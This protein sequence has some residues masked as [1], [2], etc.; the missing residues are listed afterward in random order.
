MKTLVVVD[1][2]S[3]W[4][5]Q[6]P[7]AE[8]VTAKE[9]INNPKYA[10]VPRCHILNLCRS[11]N[12]QTLGYYVSLLASAR[13][14]KPTPTLTSIEDLK[15]PSMIRFISNELDDLI[16][17]LLS[18]IHSD[19]FT[20]SIYFG[21]NVAKT[22]DRLASELYRQ[23]LAPYMQARFLKTKERWILTSIKTIAISEIPDEHRGFAIKETHRHLSRKS[24]LKQSEKRALFDLAILVDPNEEAPPS[25]KRALQKFCKAGEQLGCSV[26]LITKADFGRVAEFDALF[27]RETTRVNHHTYRFARRAIANGLEVIDDPLS[28]LRCCNKVY[29]HELL[30]KH[31]IPTPY[32]V[33]V[34]KEH[35]EQVALSMDYPCVLKQPDSAFSQGVIRVRSAREFLMQAEKLLSGS[36]LFL[37]QEY[38][39]TE[40]DWRIGVLDGK[41]LYCCR[42][43]M[44]KNHWQIIRN[45][46]TGKM[47]E[48]G[49]TSLS[50]E[51]APERVL[52]LA[53]KSANLIGNGLYGVDI[54]EVN[55][56]FYVIEV[57]DNPTIDAGVEDETLK[58][59][60]YLKI[61][62]KICERIESKQDKIRQDTQKKYDKTLCKNQSV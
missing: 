31:K 62:G 39:P 26:E 47:Q 19:Q 35:V 18:K 48:G 46:H 22:Y 44:V 52:K 7:E 32:T 45:T 53:I 3:D 60:L 40:F 9:Y 8:V 24:P 2:Q 20:L 28:I 41:A 51:E 54:K 42:Y 27:I 55:G 43:F 14:H 16:Q 13:G 4:S 33:I 59:E 5:L 50:L 57:N 10:S 12:Y 34:D 56:K 15:S 36:D 30:D 11:Y 21:K 29:L 17:K 25:N 37:A 23:L 38:L 61:I 6:H 49:S 1:K 58:D